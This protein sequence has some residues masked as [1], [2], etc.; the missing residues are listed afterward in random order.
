LQKGL[1]VGYLLESRGSRFD[2]RILRKVT[3]DNEQ[4]VEFPGPAGRLEGL[5]GNESST[6]N[7]VVVALHP[8]P[9]YGGSM[10]NNVV[11]TIVRAG[12]H[13]G[14]ATL[15]FNFR[16]VGGS[17]G[18]FSGGPGESD[19]I[20]AALDFLAKHFDVGIRVVAGYSFGAVVALAYCHRQVH[21]ADHLVLVSPPPFLLPEGIP[22]EAGVLRKIIVGEADEMAPPGG[23]IMRVSPSRRE[24]CIELLPGA[25]HFFGGMEDELERRLVNVLETIGSTEAES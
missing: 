10:H 5:L 12:R 23:V 25:D 17:D 19:D 2:R 18:E 1:T 3:M 24:E 8:H 21:N 9:L 20:G 7:G 22:L 16:G 4:P 11:E 14:L 6:R 15:R 13:S